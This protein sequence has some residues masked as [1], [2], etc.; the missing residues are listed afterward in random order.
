MNYW[1][2][3]EQKFRGNKPAWNTGEWLYINRQICGNSRNELLSEPW[4]FNYEYSSGNALT[5]NETTRDSGGK[6]SHELD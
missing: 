3:T 5:G 1:R 4:T 2:W 6:F